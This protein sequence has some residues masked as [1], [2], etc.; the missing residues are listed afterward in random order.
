[1]NLSPL[2]S[3]HDRPA[4]G[5]LQSLGFFMGLLI[6]DKL[7]AVIIGQCV[8]VFSLLAGLSLTTCTHNQSDLV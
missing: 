3:T 5:V 2:L 6:P 1:M 4:V 7:L 8:M